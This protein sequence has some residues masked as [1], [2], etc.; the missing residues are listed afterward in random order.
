MAQ[1][2]LI[3]TLLFDVLV[4]YSSNSHLLHIFSPYFLVGDHVLLVIEDAL[5]FVQVEIPLSLLICYVF[6]HLVLQLLCSI[7]FLIHLC[8]FLFYQPL[9]FLCLLQ[10]LLHVVFSQIVYDLVFLYSRY[11]ILHYLLLYV[12]LFDLQ[13]HRFEVGVEFTNLFLSPIFGRQEII[14]VV[15]Q[16]IVL[17][18]QLI[19]PLLS[20]LPVFAHI[21]VSLPDEDQTMMG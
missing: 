4:L 5:H 1:V 21:V 10:L 3:P 7:V 9:E 13:L 18:L 12:G 20:L 16:F 17:S 14:L 11:H 19:D 6:N 15:G 2:A 8:T